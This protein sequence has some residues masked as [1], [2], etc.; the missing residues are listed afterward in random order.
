MLWKPAEGIWTN[1]DL[2]GDGPLRL[3]A[4][5]IDALYISQFC[6][7]PGGEMK[8]GAAT[9]FPIAPSVTPRTHLVRTGAKL[10]GKIP[11]GDRLPLR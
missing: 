7:E 3:P 5:E 10:W 11:A 6:D 2:W 1:E 4:G 8:H 9:V